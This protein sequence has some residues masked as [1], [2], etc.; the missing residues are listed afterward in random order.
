MN[1]YSVLLLLILVNRQTQFPLNQQRDIKR[2]QIFKRLS[3]DTG[4]TLI[5][6]YDFDDSASRTSVAEVAQS[7]K[8]YKLNYPKL[9]YLDVNYVRGTS[10]IYTVACV[11]AHGMTSNY[12]PQIQAVY[13]KFRNRIVQKIISVDKAKYY[14]L[15]ALPTFIPD[16]LCTFCSRAYGHFYR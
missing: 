13:D 14:F 2:F 6:E 5:C 1:N 4:F 12:G 3:I 11:D 7:S 16:C 15:H 8:L 9:C 10:P